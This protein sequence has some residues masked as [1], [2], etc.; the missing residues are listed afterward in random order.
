MTFEDLIKKIEKHIQECS[1]KEREE[2][3]KKLEEINK[4]IKQIIGEK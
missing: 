4:K 3:I 2:A 1:N